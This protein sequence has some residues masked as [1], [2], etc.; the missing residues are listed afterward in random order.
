MTEFG[1]DGAITVPASPM[2]RPI[3][4]PVLRPLQSTVQ[5]GVRV[6]L[7]PTPRPHPAFSEMPRLLPEFGPTPSLFDRWK[8][9]FFRSECN[10]GNADIRLSKVLTA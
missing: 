1:N 8:P 5:S 2:R 6:E 3:R 7:A 10:P 4:F 9:G